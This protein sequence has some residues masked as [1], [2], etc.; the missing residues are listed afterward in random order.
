MAPYLMLA[1]AVV[2][3]VFG[4][5]MMKLSHGFEKKAPLIGV[6]AG[7]LAAFYLIAQTLEQ[8]PLGFTYAAWTGLGIALTAVVGALFWKEPFNAKKIVGIIAVIA[9][10]VLLKLGV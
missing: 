8:L 6:A 2:C 1:V 5:S 3:E 7:Y 10:V 4:D 9:G